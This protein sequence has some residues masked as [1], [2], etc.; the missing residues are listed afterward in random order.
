MTSIQSRPSL[1]EIFGS[2]S[3]PENNARPSLDEIFGATTPNPSKGFAQ[4]PASVIE[5]RNQGMEEQL[6]NQP[7]Q[8]S[9]LQNIGSGIVQGGKNVVMGGLQAG[10][11]IAAKAFP[12]NQTIKDFRSLLPEAQ[13]QSNL[14]YQA[15]TGDS[16]AAGVGRLGA[17]VA[18]YGVMGGPIAGGVI[19]GATQPS[20]KQRTPEEALRD[21]A[22]SGAIGGTLGAVAPYAVSKMSDG[23]G[24]I[25]KGINPTNPEA[26]NTIEAGMKKVGSGLYD[27]MED[28]K[29]NI[30]PTGTKELTD[31]IY[32][33]LKDKLGGLDPVAHKGTISILKTLENDINN[34]IES[35]AVP[36]GTV[37]ILD[38]LK[39]PSEAGEIT[40]KRLDQIRRSLSD[41]NPL[42][43]GDMK[44][45]AVVRNAIDESL[46]QLK[47]ENLTNGSTEAIQ[48]LNAARSQ[49][50]QASKFEMISNIIKDAGGDRAKIKSKLDALL[51]T[52][53]EMKI[54]N[55]S[56]D[57]LAALKI[58]AKSSV[59]EKILNGLGV[60][61]I[62]GGKKLPLIGDAALLYGT[63]ANPVAIGGI[64]GSTGADMLSK[65]MARGKAEQ[66]IKVIQ[67]GKTP[68]ELGTLPPRVATQLLQMYKG[69]K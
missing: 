61:S 55:F 38:R 22:V 37:S 41:I 18:V 45:A 5:T 8:Q 43:K 39:D 49:W 35:A 62:A 23:I 27:H 47:P 40:V 63:H 9:M 67:S 10:T 6:A 65:Y 36:E 1:D 52:N 32:T 50:S 19:A 17:E 57:E 33:A 51:K 28:I 56:D 7:T 48:A 13:A 15:Q 34:K 11:D 2:A 12:E 20:E 54:S 21:R 42:D 59:P 16:T 44:A 64:I 60:A 29:A 14:K 30:A 53:K 58:A 3:V 4:N 24:T 69:K 25:I 68:K 31:N 46:N 66:L 26:L